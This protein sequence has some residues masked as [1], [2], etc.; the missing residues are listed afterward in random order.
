MR[1]YADNLFYKVLFLGGHTDNTL[2]ATVLCGIG[3]SRLAL[4]IT[5]VSE[6]NNALVALDKVFK[7]NILFSRKNISSK[8]TISLISQASRPISPRIIPPSTAR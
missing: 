2:T 7:E 3:I 4:N 1:M 8:P 6:C 5:C